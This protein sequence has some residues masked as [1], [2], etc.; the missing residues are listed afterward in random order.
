MQAEYYTY[1]INNDDLMDDCMK[2]LKNDLPIFD[3]MEYNRVRA[4]AH[5][6]HITLIVFFISLLF[7]LLL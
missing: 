5:S 3:E 7:A 1:T 2:L 6:T 4:A